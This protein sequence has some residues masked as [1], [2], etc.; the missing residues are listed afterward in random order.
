MLEGQHAVPE[1]DLRLADALRQISSRFGSSAPAGVVVLSD[2]RVRAAEA[3][4]QI[5]R[6]LGENGVPIHVVPVGEPGSGGDLAVISA[7]VPPRVRK[8][9]DFEIQISDFVL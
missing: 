4:E 7:V 6:R 3:T 2:G 9:S 5:A 1:G 8:Y